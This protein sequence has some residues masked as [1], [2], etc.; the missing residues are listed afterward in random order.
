MNISSMQANAASRLMAA[1]GDRSGQAAN[2]H[3]LAKSV[4]TG[5]LDGAKQAY[6]SIIQDAPEGATWPKDSAF[7]KLGVALAT[8]NGDAAK[9]ILGDALRDARPRQTTQP[10][11]PQPVVDYGGIGGNLNLVA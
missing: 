2:L 5:D 4:R 3:D 11:A 6:K 7:S 8:C 10:V 1:T 9:T